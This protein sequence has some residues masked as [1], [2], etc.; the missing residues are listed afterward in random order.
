MLVFEV[1]KRYE[2]FDNLTG[3]FLGKVGNAWYNDYTV[4]M[5]EL[6]DDRY[7]LVLADIFGDCHKE[8]RAYFPNE[9][10]LDEFLEHFESNSINNEDINM[11]LD[12]KACLNGYGKYY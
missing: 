3:I 8:V 6:D 12:V 2:I 4:A 9:E 10:E 7:L 11:M 5:F 1:G